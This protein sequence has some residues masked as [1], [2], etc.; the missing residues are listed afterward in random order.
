MQ[1]IAGIVRDR[2]GEKRER[3]VEERIFFAYDLSSAIA[4]LHLHGIIHRDLKPDNI[5]FDIV[6]GNDDLPCSTERFLLFANIYIS[7]QL[8][9]CVFVAG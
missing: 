9:I 3:L 2:K 4:H 8:S 1:G 7:H 5:G 6:S